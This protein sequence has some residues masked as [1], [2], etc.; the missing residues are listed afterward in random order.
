[1]KINAK[2]TEINA[3]GVFKKP[4]SVPDIPDAKVRTQRSGRVM[5]PF[6]VP[7]AARLQLR[8]M[9]AQ[10][11]STQQDLLVVALNDFFRKHNLPAIA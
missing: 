8:V 11:D 7:L 3:L 4:A 6:Y 5:L 10:I 2:R 9:A 1:M